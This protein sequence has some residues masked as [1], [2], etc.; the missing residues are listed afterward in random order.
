[1]ITPVFVSEVTA[2]DVRC[3]YAETFLGPITITVGADD[4]LLQL[5]YTAPPDAIRRDPAL[6][7]LAA[8]IVDALSSD[9]DMAV[10]VCPQVSPFQLDI[11]RA[12]SR[13]PRGTLASYSSIAS[14]AGHP[15]AIRA[16]AS[17]VARNPLPIIIPCHRIVPAGCT[18]SPDRPL[19]NPRVLGNYTPRRELKAIILEKEGY[20]SQKK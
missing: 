15:S 11:L 16:A 20:F 14:M 7:A 12:V 18:A 10:R 3:G 8:E 17:A 6:D 19:R 5:S 4:T 9:T 1:M 2:G 13:V